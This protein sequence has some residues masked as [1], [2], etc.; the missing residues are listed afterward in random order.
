[1][2]V[3]A[4]TAKRIEL[5]ISQLGSADFKQREAAT[6]ELVGL[7]EHSYSAL[8]QAAKSGN[9]EVNRRAKEA[10]KAIAETVPA[11]RLHVPQYDTVVAADFTIIGR[12]ETATLKART[13]YFGETNL[14]LTDLRSLRWL[15]SERETKV[16]VDAARYGSAQ[17]AWLDTGIDIRAGAALQINA[18]GVVDLRPAAGEA[19]TFLVGLMDRIAFEG[20]AAV[21]AATRFLAVLAAVSLRAAACPLA[22]P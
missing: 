2:R 4:E 21:A 7:R 6:S 16:A 8:Q 20:R 12:V 14:Q 15:S 22:E 18:S 13:P 11:E 17:E 3:P 1:M 10:L 9:A 5:A 19:G